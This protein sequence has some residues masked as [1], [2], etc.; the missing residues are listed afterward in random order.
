MFKHC[1]SD[2][3]IYVLHF[4]DDTLLVSIYVYD[5]VITRNNPNLILGLKRKLVDSF[6]MI[7]LGIL[8]FFLGLQVLPLP[9]GIFIFCSKYALDLLKH[10]KMDDYKSC[11][12]YF[13]LGVKLIKE[14]D[15][16]KVYATLHL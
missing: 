13:Q 4:H 16:L 9:N 10:F 14:F 7:D 2:H 8:R 6:E 11:T 12:T 1:E 3:I 5:L 15:Y